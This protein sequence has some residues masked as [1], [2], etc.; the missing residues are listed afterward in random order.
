VWNLTLSLRGQNELVKKAFEN[1]QLRRIFGS[2]SEEVTG[3]PILTFCFVTPCIV[4]GYQRFEE[5]FCL[6]LQGRNDR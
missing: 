5:I 2:K 3:L 4:G 1:G 6:H